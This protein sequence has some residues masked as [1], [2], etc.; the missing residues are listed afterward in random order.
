[1][2]KIVNRVLSAGD[3][4]MPERY[5]KH[6]GFTLLLVSYLITTKK[7]FRNF[8]KQKIQNIFADMS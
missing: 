8:E 7:E 3:K 2:N 4:F 5:L 6:P 1:M